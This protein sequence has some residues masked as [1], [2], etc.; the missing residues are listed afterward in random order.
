[1]RIR[2]VDRNDRGEVDGDNL[3]RIKTM[4]EDGSTLIRIMSGKKKSS[5]ENQTVPVKSRRREAMGSL[6]G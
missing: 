6:P 3:K 2:A 5:Q 1:M 4:Y